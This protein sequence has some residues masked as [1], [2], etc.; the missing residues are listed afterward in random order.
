MR[1]NAGIEQDELKVRD[2]KD[3]W[4]KNRKISRG[5]MERLIN[6]K[7]RDQYSNANK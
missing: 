3:N 1:I 2:T 5:E 4:G 7:Q 6:E